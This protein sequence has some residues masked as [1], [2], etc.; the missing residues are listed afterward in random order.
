VIIGDQPLLEKYKI[1]KRVEVRGVKSAGLGK[2]AFFHILR[3]SLAA[4]EFK[5]LGETIIAIQKA[6]WLERLMRRTHAY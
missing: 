5:K 1:G 3:K 4:M 2:E 6:N